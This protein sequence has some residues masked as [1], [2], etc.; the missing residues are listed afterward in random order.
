[1]IILLCF[2]RPKHPTKVHVWAGISLRGPTKICIF[3]GIMDATLFVDILDSTLVTFIAE[4]YGRGHRLMQ[5]NDPK[6]ASLYVQSF[7]DRKGI[8]WWKTP[9][10]SP[11]LNLIENLWHEL[12]EVIRRELKPHTQDEL[13]LGIKQFWKTVSKCTRFTQ[14][15]KSA[16]LYRLQARFLISYYSYHVKHIAIQCKV[17]FIRMCYTKY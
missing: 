14:C 1:M 10:E 11:D 9:A 2:D 4:M 3:D 5:D 13:V 17:A 15:F 12:K 7:Y 8:N 6:H 16:L